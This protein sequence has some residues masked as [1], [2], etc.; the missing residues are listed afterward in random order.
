MLAAMIYQVLSLSV[1]ALMRTLAPGE[2]ISLEK[3]FDDWSAAILKCH[4]MKELWNYDPD[5]RHLKMDAHP[6]RIPLENTWI[7][8][9][10]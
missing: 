9:L 6:G 1:M 7:S 3:L 5:I 2:R 10:S 8:L 4:M